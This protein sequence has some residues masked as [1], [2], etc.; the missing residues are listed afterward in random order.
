MPGLQFYIELIDS[1]PKIFRRV[2]VPFEYTFHKF[3]LAIQGAFGWENSHLFRFSETGFEDKL[4]YE[5]LTEDSNTYPEFV[6]KDARRS[7]IKLVFTHDKK[8]F[9]YIYDF[10]DSWK[11]LIVHEKFVDKEIERPYCIDGAGACPPEDCGGMRGYE[12]MLATLKT[13]NDPERTNYIEWLGLAPNEKW[14][15][16]FCSIRE[17]NKR[18][19]LL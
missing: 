18:L 19:C 1:D 8:K 11:H 14:D 15:E 3:H 2:V 12:C 17:V 16:S 6:V 4:S 10:G 13:P 7:K 9:V 5:E